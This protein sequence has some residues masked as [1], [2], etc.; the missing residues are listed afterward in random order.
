MPSGGA[1]V[2]SISRGHCAPI[3]AR[4]ATACGF[5][6]T[7]PPGRSPHG[8]RTRFRGESPRRGLSLGVLVTLAALVGCRSDLSQQ[9]LERE[10]RYQEDQIYQLQDELQ[11]ARSRL[12]RTS[13]ENASYRRQLGVDGQ[14]AAPRTAPA[15]P[16][17]DTL[18]AP[19]AVPPARSLP[20]AAAPSAAPGPGRAAPPVDLAPPALEGVPPLPG[21]GALLAP[22]REIPL[23]DE[24]VLSLPSATSPPPSND[25]ELLRLA[26][27]VPDEPLTV[28]DPPVD[29]GRATHLVV[30]PR[31]TACL[32]TDGDGTSDGLTLVFEPRDDA[33]RLAAAVGD[34][35]VAVFDPA[36]GSDTATGQAAAIA[37]W[38]IP[39]A[40]AAARFR[41]TSRQRGIQVTLPWPGLPPQG[42]HVRVAV[43]L[44][45]AEGPPLEGDAT[46]P[47]R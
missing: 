4:G 33:A 38:E 44:V 18:P 35:T 1:C 37:N 32:D 2:R 7:K 27:A 10:L 15:R 25:R 16:S 24:G 30:N 39:A 14:A 42:D 21:A 3:A 8:N 26:H 41:R 47:V 17:R 28:S 20:D 6:G 9:L 22:P 19:M 31:Q 11:M 13:S 23:G 12:A 34:V 43:R 5:S 40:E 29:V 45:P 36:T 46:I